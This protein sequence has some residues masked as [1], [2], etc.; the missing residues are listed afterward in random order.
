MSGLFRKNVMMGFGFT[1]AT[2]SLIGLPLFF[3]FYA[4]INMLQSAFALNMWI[5]A[6]IILGSIIEGIY[7]IRLLVKLW[8]PGEE[9]QES[10]ELAQ[11]QFVIKNGFSLSLIAVLIG[12][13]FVVSGIIP[14][15]LTENIAK[16]ADSL[17]DAATYLST[18]LGGI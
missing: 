14:D 5:P 15:F 12:I 4:K 6:L 18:V 8:N 17:S 16:A 3:G 1:V 9:G 10:S 7:Y 11:S 13:I 2:L